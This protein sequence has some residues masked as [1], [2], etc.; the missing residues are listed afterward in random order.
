MA[1][2]EAAAQISASDHRV[3]GDAGLV[4]G[5]PPFVRRHPARSRARVAE[6]AATPLSDP[7]IFHRIRRSAT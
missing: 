2:P 5:S 6:P 3:L 1:T 4:G 7:T